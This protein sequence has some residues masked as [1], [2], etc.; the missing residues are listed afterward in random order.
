M[1]H[2][3]GTDILKS[4]Q[5]NKACLISGDPFFERVF[6]KKEQRDGLARTNPYDYFCTRF[7]GKEAV[8]KSIGIEGDH[9]R[10]KEIEILSSDIGRPYVVL[11]GQMKSKAKGLGID[12]IH[13]SLSYDS[14]YYIAYATAEKTGGNE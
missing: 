3:I 12:R 7:A 13:I 14:A 11:K 10:L 2:G 9:I 8:F 6:S 5:L 4:G 1:I